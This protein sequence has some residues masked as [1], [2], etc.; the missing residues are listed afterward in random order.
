MGKNLTVNN[1]TWASNPGNAQLKPFIWLHH[2]L[3]RILI[4]SALLILS[5]WLSLYVSVGFVIL[6][7]L[8]LLANLFYWIRKKEHFKSGDS[9]GGIVV[10]GNPTLVAIATDFTK[11]FGNY[12]V[13]K[14]VEFE[15]LKG[16]AVGDRIATV[17]LYSSS[18]NERSM[19]WVDFHPIPLSFATND[20]VVLQR[21]LDSYN[22][23]HWDLLQNRL[24]TVPK[25]YKVGLY[26]IQSPLSDW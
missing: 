13:V 24:E 26:K 16:R 12:P 4:M 19:H 7:F 15:T 23:E 5:V 17:A 9:N 21:A 2:D 25:P 22:Q 11:G 20:Q 10:S 6:A 8:L 18:G 1:K 14:I 3:K